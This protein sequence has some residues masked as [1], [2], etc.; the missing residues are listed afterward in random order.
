MVTNV[1]IV[2]NFGF[3]WKCSSQI[4][5][6]KTDIPMKKFRNNFPVSSLMAACM[7]FLCSFSGLAQE[8]ILTANDNATGAGG[9]VSYSVGQV[10]FITIGSGNGTVT[11]GVQQP[12]EILFMTGVDDEK[13]I[14]PNCTVFPNPAHSEV[15]LKMDKQVIGQLNYQLRN[16][17]GLLLSD[18]KIETSETIIP[19]NEQPAGIYLLTVIDENKNQTTWKI[20]KK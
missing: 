1:I 6:E 11:E 2:I 16:S 4:F 9:T 3:Q 8:S 17:N 12:Y 5:I 14:S 20:I 18:M 13:A 10:A 15:M 19:L 7:L